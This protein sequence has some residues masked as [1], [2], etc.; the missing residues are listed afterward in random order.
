M[1]ATSRRAFLAMTAAVAPQSFDFSADPAEPDKVIPLW[2]EGRMPGIATRKMAERV[3][4]QVDVL[5]LRYRVAEQVQRPSIAYFRPEKPN[6]AAILIIPGGGYTRV[7]IDREGYETA[8]WSRAQGVAAFVLRYRLP[9]DRWSSGPKVAFQD[10]QRAMRL[11][12]A[13]GGWSIDPARVAVLGGSAGGHLAGSLCTR[14]YEQSYDAVDAADRFV[15]R[16]DGAVLLYPVVSMQAGFDSASRRALLGT[17]PVQADADAWSLERTIP[18]VSPPLMLVH[19]LADR[20][21][22][23]RHTMLLFEAVRASGGAVDLHLFQDGA[24]GLGLRGDP[25]WPMSEWPTLAL[26][27]LRRNRLA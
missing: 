19:S 27:W 6:G 10:A 4:D 21:V 25:S 3:I 24:H 5:G 8:R 14:V 1:L 12:R 15:T 11:I 22:P 23:W 26:R 20:T 18:S 2:P 16:P 13:G 17:D 9:G 7:G